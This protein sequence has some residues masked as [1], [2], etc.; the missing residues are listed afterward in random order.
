MGKATRTRQQSAREKIAAQ[1]AAA[2]RAETRRRLF[3]TAGSVVAVIAVV[4]AFIVV[5]SLNKPAAQPAGPAG[6]TGV[7]LPA[8]VAKNV[9]GVPAS[10]LNTVGAGSVPQTVPKPVTVING[11]PLTSNG[12]VDRLALSGRR[13]PT[14]L[15]ASPE[16]GRLDRRIKSG[17]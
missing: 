17:E 9:T 6:A 8:A 3:I 1:Q 5:R 2:R 15:A 4:V 7:L 16:P 14:G 11:P 12:K 10:T 13:A